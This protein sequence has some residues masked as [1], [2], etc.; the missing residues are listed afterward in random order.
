MIFINLQIK[1]ANKITMP[2]LKHSN[3]GVKLMPL[4]LFILLVSCQ[5]EQQYEE[6]Q[7]L[8]LTEAQQKQ[9]K[10]FGAYLNLSKAMVNANPIDG[11]NAAKEMEA[12][13]KTV[14]AGSFADSNRQVWDS[15]STAIFEGLTHINNSDDIKE[16]RVGYEK[17]S[18]N[19]YIMLQD[20][21]MI[22]SPAYRVFCPMAFKDKGAYWISDKPEVRN[23]YFGDDMLECGE[24]T[25]TLK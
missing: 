2:N 6:D 11:K 7:M 9:Q 13:L 10:V 4:F 18:D 17:V 5:N 19:Y 3:W 20:F 12:D 24:V 21:D 16:Q 15:L 22:Y 1:T 8:N 14:D 25:D 23:P